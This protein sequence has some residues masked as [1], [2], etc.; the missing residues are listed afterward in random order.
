MNATEKAI[1]TLRTRHGIKLGVPRARKQYTE[2]QISYL[3][4]LSA[5]GLF[6]AEITRR[7]NERF[8]TN[9]TETAIQL[10][11][12]QYGFQT[13]ARNCFKKGHVPWNK[14]LK[15]VNFGGQ[16]T[17]F[18]PGHKPHNWVPVGSERVNADGYMEVKIQ[19][20]KLQKNWKG[21]HVLIWEQHNSQPVPPGHA[22]IFGDGNR[23]NFDP[24]NLILVSRA[25]L[26]RM[27]QSGLIKNDAAL[28]KTGVI[29]ADLL[30]K[31][32]ERKK[33]RAE[34]KP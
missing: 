10:Q 6:N 22:V 32:G 19:D 1:Q 2:E 13:T 4:E 29:I 28:T 21:K 7:F 5:Q 24:E 26:A 33:Q 27:N 23:R 34:V 3:K 31:I 12:V 30:N 11:R 15:G 14:G 16:K 18:K 20:G 9:R 25:Q 8:G 17:Q